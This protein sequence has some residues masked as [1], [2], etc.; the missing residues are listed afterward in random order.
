MELAK[1]V[2][3]MYNLPIGL[4]IRIVQVCAK[5]PGSKVY[6][7]TIYEVTIIIYYIV[8]LLEF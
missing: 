2:G 5:M 8:I 7:I 1:I 6:I 3:G 4:L